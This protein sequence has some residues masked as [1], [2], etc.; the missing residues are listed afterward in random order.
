ME[1][2][3]LGGLSVLSVPAIRRVWWAYYCF[4][5]IY[6]GKLKPNLS[7]DR[8]LP[9]LFKPVKF[10]I[11]KA[12]AILSPQLLSVGFVPQ[13]WKPV[14]KKGT[15]AGSVVNY[16]PISLTCAASK[17]MERSLMR[18]LTEKPLLSNVQ[19]G[20]VKRR[21]TCSNLLESLNDW[22][23]TIQDGQ[24]VVV[25]YID[26]NKAFD[27]VSHEKLF[28]YLNQYGVRGKL[29]LWLTH[30]LSV[31]EHIKHELVLHCLLLLTC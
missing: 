12:R 1:K 24:S 3:L 17:N 8:L 31:A 9:W 5:Y 27:S 15:A 11:A 13:E 4:C 7:S 20:F 25:G 16:R 28:Y 2:S 22:T 18:H 6:I 30:F 29:L 23:L 10:S 26:F 14:F 21:S 19:H